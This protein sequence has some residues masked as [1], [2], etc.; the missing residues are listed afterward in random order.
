MLTSGSHNGRIVS[1]SKI[2][3]TSSSPSINASH[4]GYTG[5]LDGTQCAHTRRTEDPDV[6][7]K[8]RTDLSRTHGQVLIEDAIDDRYD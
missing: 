5:H 2:S 7:I 8:R 4:A 6:A 1:G 3:A